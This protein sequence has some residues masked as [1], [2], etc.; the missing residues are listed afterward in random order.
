VATGYSPSRATAT[1]VGLAWFLLQA[2]TCS[3][4]VPPLNEP[5]TYTTQ[6][7]RSFVL[8][9]PNYGDSNVFL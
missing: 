8:A 2:G 9:L 5:N 6:V 4:Q 1:G 7:G 3:S